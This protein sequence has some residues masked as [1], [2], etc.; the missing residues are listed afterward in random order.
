MFPEIKDELVGYLKDF[1]FKN[2]DEVI[3][4]KFK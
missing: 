2:I 4:A 1:T 3:Q